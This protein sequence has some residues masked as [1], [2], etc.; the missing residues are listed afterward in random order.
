MPGGL[1]VHPDKEHIVYPLG[2]TIVV[3]N[4]STHLQRFLSGHNDNVSC[5]AISKTGCNIASGQHTHM[6]FKAEV[7]VW[8]YQ[9]M[10]IYCRLLLHKVTV[11]ALAFSPNEKFLATLGGQDDGRFL[12]FNLNELIFFFFLM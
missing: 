2:N 11:E 10:R 7:I 12:I 9:E 1:L 3:K 4:L 5:V 8:N 6:G